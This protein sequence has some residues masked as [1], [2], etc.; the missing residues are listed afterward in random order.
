M[1]G[2]GLALSIIASRAPALAQPT[3]NKTLAE[4]LF[5]QGRALAKANNW[6]EACPKFEAS[7]HYDATLGTRLN[8]ATCYEKT[9]KLASAW[10]QYRDSAALARGPDDAQ[11]REYALKQAAALLPRLPKLTITAPPTTPPGFAVTRDGVALDLA[12]LGSALYVDPGPHEIVASAPGLEPFKATIS[13]DEAGSESLVIQ[14]LVP[15]KTPVEPQGQPQPR[16]E[17]PPLPPSSAGRTRKLVGLGIAGGGAILTGVGLFV[18]ARAIS[19]YD[20]SEALCPSRKCVNE[21][22]LA[23]GDDLTS[24]ARGQATTSTVLVVTGL[25]AA[26]AGVVVWL[27]APKRERTETV[28]VPVVTDRELGLAVTGRF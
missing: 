20:E 10:G 6:T 25:A 14:E 13:V 3:D 7:L 9:G 1:L 18:G 15:A 16:P 23:R 28:F 27:A 5:E 8:L 11:R 21:A 26:T 4:Q 12:A 19:T 17:V 24:R 2:T 22:D